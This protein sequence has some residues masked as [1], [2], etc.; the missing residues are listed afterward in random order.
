MNVY[1]HVQQFLIPWLFLSLFHKCCVRAQEQASA[2]TSQQLAPLPATDLHSHLKALLT[3]SLPH[4]SLGLHHSLALHP[5]LPLH[6]PLSLPPLTPGS[7]I[8]HHPS[9]LM[10]QTFPHLP[11]TFR[12]PATS[13]T[14]PKASPTIVGSP[15]VASSASVYAPQPSNKESET[16]AIPVVRQVNTS[17]TDV[18]DTAG[19]EAIIKS[20]TSESRHSSQEKNLSA[21]IQNSPVVRKS[22]SKATLPNTIL[23]DVETFL[24]DVQTNESSSAITPALFGNTT[25]ADTTILQTTVSD[26]STTSTISTPLPKNTPGKGKVVKSTIASIETVPTKSLLPSENTALENK[27]LESPD[28]ENFLQSTNLSAQDAQVFLKLVE[29]VLEEEVARRLQKHTEQAA[30]DSVINDKRNTAFGGDEQRGERERI[31]NQ[32][33]EE[34]GNDK[35]LSHELKTVNTHL[36][37]VSEEVENI[38][39]ASKVVQ[40]AARGPTLNISRITTTTTITPFA[41]VEQRKSVIPVSQKHRHSASSAGPIIVAGDSSQNDAEDGSDLPLAGLQPDAGRAEHD[42]R[43]IEQAEFDRLLDKLSSE[44]GRRGTAEDSDLLAAVGYRGR[45][46]THASLGRGRS[47]V[48]ARFKSSVVPQSPIIPT[49]PATTSLPTTQQM[50]N[51]RPN[52]F[53]VRHPPK[54]EFE[55]LVEDYRYRL[56]GGQNGFNDLMKALRNA[57]IVYRLLE[58]KMISDYSHAVYQALGKI[59]EVAQAID[60]KL[61]REIGGIIVKHAHEQNICVVLA[62][63]HFDLNSSEGMLE[64]QVGDERVSKPERLENILDSG[65]HPNVIAFRDGKWSPVSFALDND[66]DTCPWRDLKFLSEVGGYLTRTGVQDKFLLAIRASKT[67]K[68]SG[69]RYLELNYNETRTSVTVKYNGEQLGSIPTTYAFLKNKDGVAEESCVTLCRPNSFGGHSEDGHK[70]NK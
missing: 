53:S 51:G 29:K 13:A 12:L 31:L 57:H 45:P 70:S 59:E 50:M 48:Q 21:E 42:Y 26:V 62:H 60:L 69:L 32:L 61:V 28:L 40:S 17:L 63:K 10:V 56:A 20:E 27:R 24:Y 54:T 11:A 25:S 38:G 19:H 66:A 3:H 16:S 41:N 6:H 58:H 47:A 55:H 5:Q 46:V 44:T 7:A 49:Q 2:A 67:E 22:Q 9:A 4:E 43:T 37:Y 33:L 30:N 65:A 34:S 18:S 35:L 64:T 14:Q 39:G 68:D 8:L 52:K 36:S 1:E 15:T 23:Q